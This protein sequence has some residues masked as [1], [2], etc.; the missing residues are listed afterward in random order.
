MDN[1]NVSCGCSHWAKPVKKSMG[2]KVNSCLFYFFSYYLSSVT[3][4]GIDFPTTAAAATTIIMIL[5]I[6]TW[7]LMVVLAV[8]ANMNPGL[9]K[10]F[11]YI[12][13]IQYEVQ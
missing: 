8:V 13:S 3:G 6:I 10:R 12:L 2:N 7:M 4:S 9:V 1:F 5:V 11:L